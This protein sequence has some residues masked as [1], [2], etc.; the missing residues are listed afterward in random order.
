MSYGPQDQNAHPYPPQ[1]PPQPYGPGYGQQ[2]PPYTQ[3]ARRSQ[4]L[5]I[6]ALVLGALACGLALLPIR[7]IGIVLGLVAVLLAIIALVAKGQ[8]GKK[9]AAGG[10]AL[11]MASLPLAFV[12]YTLTQGQER[13]NRD[14]V[15]KIQE[16]IEDD[17]NAV[18]ECSGWK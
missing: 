16:C 3:P 6:A 2:R 12:M 18:L 9:L 7:G 14:N 10:L 11:G 5:A 17:P 8:G 15:Q 4:G 1:G 13:A